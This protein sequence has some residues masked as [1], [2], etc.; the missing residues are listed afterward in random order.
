MK[1]QKKTSSKHLDPT[2]TE[3]FC[4]SKCISIINAIFVL[5]AF[6]LV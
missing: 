2:S 5:G 1:E 3:K 6:I 4:C